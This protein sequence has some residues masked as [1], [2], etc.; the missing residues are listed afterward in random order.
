MRLDLIAKLYEQDM[1]GV[2]NQLYYQHLL[3][4][5]ISKIEQYF[6]WLI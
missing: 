5:N 4:T 6:S 3:T 2:C 1:N